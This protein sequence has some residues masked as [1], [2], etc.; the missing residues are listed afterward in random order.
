MSFFDELDSIDIIEEHV[1][2][3]TTL[4][5]SQARG[6][7]KRYKEI[8]QELRDRLDR[9]PGDRFSAQQLRGVLTQVDGAIIA[10]GESLKTGMSD[11][12][13]DMALKG[14]Q[15]ALKEIKVFQDYF[16]GAVVPINI[17]AQLV[18]QDTQN[19]LINQYEAS[20]NAYSE[21]VRSD[22]VQTLTMESLAE[23]PYSTIIRK[24]GAYFQGEEWKLQ[25][26]ARTELMSIL[27]MGKTNAM[28]A[29]RDDTLPDLKKA[30]YTPRDNRTA[31]DSIYADGLNLIAD[32]D[33]P[34]KYKWKGK[35]RVFF[36]TDRPNDRSITI[37]YRKAWE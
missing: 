17:N 12:A 34:F 5:E 8:R 16:K 3:V 18:A 36:G 11:S 4:E 26:I 33:E 19:F 2:Q 14:V 27:S 30:R 28:I 21:G 22:L 31:A 32:L 7:L 29:V 9:L 25:R 15:D 1:K 10:M 20:I 6:L 35:M 23:T 13:G 24:L 37:P